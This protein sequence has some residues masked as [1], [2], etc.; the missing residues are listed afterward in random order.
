MPRKV[1]ESPATKKLG[2]KNVYKLVI[3][4]NEAS[5][6]LKG[7][8]ILEA[9]QHFVA[10]VPMKTDV[11]IM[12]TKGSKTVDKEVRVREARYTFTNPT[13]L[14]LLAKSLSIRLG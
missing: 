14:Q 13:A 6:A 1:K 11:L 9:L 4:A 3:T 12:V 10:P 5:Q 8:T 7:E 2:A